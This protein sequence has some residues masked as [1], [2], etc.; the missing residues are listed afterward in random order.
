VCALTPA[1]GAG[2]AAEM[3]DDEG[4]KPAK[5]LTYK[6]A[7]SLFVRNLSPD[8]N[9]QVLREVFDHDVIEK[10]S[11]R[12]FPNSNNQFFAQIDFVSSTGV[13]EGSKLS[14]VLILGVPC[15]VGVVDP[16]IS[17]GNR[18]AAASSGGS[19]GAAGSTDEVLDIAEVNRR[20][21]EASEDQRMRTIHIA[22]LA[23]GT[24]DEQLERLVLKFGELERLKVDT[25]TK[26]ACFGLVEFKDRGPAHI[27]KT[28]RSF[29]VDDRV[30]TVTEAKSMVEESSFMEQ[31]IQFQAPII[32]AMAMKNVLYQQ[33]DLREKLDKVREAARSIAS[34]APE[35]LEEEA[36]EAPAGPGAIAAAK[37]KVKELLEREERKKK[38]A[39]KKEVKKLKKVEKKQKKKEKKKT[40]KAKAAAA[41]P[42]GSESEDEDAVDISESPDGPVDLVDEVE[43]VGNTELVM[44]GDESSSSSG[45][46]GG[47]AEKIARAAA[48]R[49]AQKLS[50]ATVVGD[51]NIVTLGGD[52]PGQWTVEDGGVMSFNG[53]RLKSEKWGFVQETEKKEE[54]TNMVLF[55]RGQRFAGWELDLKVSTVDRLVWKRAGDK[56]T[57]WLRKGAKAK[58]KAKAKSAKAT[59]PGKKQ[60]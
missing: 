17:E 55:C 29:K 4:F 11:F 21:T 25:D 7:H 34:K 53:R 16:I 48:R 38:K 10:I 27:A 45:S 46:E 3:S 18:R 8:V 2:S 57:H 36:E 49:R 60:R 37:A 39:E 30:L 1:W 54:G 14:G 32:D 50:V 47:R 28:Q 24:T 15:E 6:A 58:G 43:L 22:G 59:K 12:A 5:R 51:W 26:G 19:G 13:T 31:T 52:P 41:A 35:Q 40:R 20:I 56:D 44:L 33:L 42:E 9:E 23:P